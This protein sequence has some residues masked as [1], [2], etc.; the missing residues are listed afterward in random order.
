MGLDV[1][2]YEIV[3]NDSILTSKIASDELYKYCS[4]NGLHSIVYSDFEQNKRVNDLFEHKFKK[5]TGTVLIDNYIDYEFYNKKH[6]CKIT[7]L[8]EVSAYCYFNKIINFDLMMKY[9]QFKQLIDD[10]FKDLTEDSE[11]VLSFL[12]CDDKIVEVTDSIKTYTC[13]SKYLLFKH[14][15]YQRSGDTSDLYD[16]FYGDCW[17]KKEDCNLSH[18]DVRW[19]IYADELKELKSC[20]IDGSFIKEWSLN[21]NEIIYLNA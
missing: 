9:P 12:E 15:N 19:F 2:K 6:N 14:T 18:D 11:V 8:Y 4:E 16:K 20:F 5:F 1:Y 3:K 13:E 10:T 17:Y 7:W 21:K